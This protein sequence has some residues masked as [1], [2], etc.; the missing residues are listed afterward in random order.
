MSQQGIEL[1]APAGNL[2][3]F[4]KVICAGADAVYFGGD[5]FGARAF[6]DNFS[7]EDC[8]SAIKYAH[9]HGVKAYLTVNTLL[10]NREILDKLYDYIYPLY[11]SGLDA[12]IVQDFGVFE[13]LRYYF[14]DLIIHAS[15]QMAICNSDGAAFLKE[16]GASRIV[17]ARELSIEEIHNIYQNTDMEIETFVHGALCVCYSGD[18]YMSSMLGGRSGN[19]GR[20]AQPCRLPYEAYED[21]HKLSGPGPYLLSPK[22]LMGIDYLQQ[23]SDAGVYSFKI[24]G[25]MKSLEYAAG[26]VS[27]Y[28]RNIDAILENSSHTVSKSDKKLLFDL[29]NRS[30]FTDLYYTAQNGPEM[31]SFEEGSHKKADHALTEDFPL[32]KVPISAFF[33]G[34]VGQEMILTLNSEDNSVTISGPY[35][36]EAKNRPTSEEDVRKSLSKVG[37]TDFRLDSLEVSISNDAFLPVKILNELRRTAISKLEDEILASSNRCVT[38]RPYDRSF[39]SAKIPS[40]EGEKELLLTVRTKE[41]LDALLNALDSGIDSRVILSLDYSLI[42]ELDLGMMNKWRDNSNILIYMSFPAVFRSRAK[43]ILNARISEYSTVFDGFLVSSY[44]ELSYL[45][46]K[47]I[48]SSRIIFDHRLYGFSSMALR[49]FAELGDYRFTA[50]LELNQ[51]ELKHLDNGRSYLTIYGRAPLMITANCTNHNLSGCDGR[52][53]HISLKDR[54]GVYF[55]VENDCKICMNTIYNSKITSLLGEKSAVSTMGFLG[56]R[57]DFTVESGK[58]VEKALTLYKDVFLRDEFVTF[59]DRFTKGH[60]KRGVD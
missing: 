40:Y 22:D 10:K 6:A 27:V 20:C 53:H 36:E 31:M 57:M 48:L 19:R 18:C 45:E 11:L 23:L 8:I 46:S 4:K 24:E 60:F 7:P 39:L 58:D 50:S 52:C 21:G 3:I 42:M 55:P 34:Q 12:V 13:F 30:G 15:T 5:M 44:D 25:R 37:N 28:R 1:L 33:Y 29:G 51:S 47:G 41:Q 59:D 26:V 32:K 56:Y 17:T 16:L 14:P 38:A 54:M 2:E 49:A 9:L 43:K 35:V